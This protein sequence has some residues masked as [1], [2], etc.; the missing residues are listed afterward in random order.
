MI[1]NIPDWVCE[2]PPQFLGAHVKNESNEDSVDSA[3]HTPGSV[4]ATV[5]LII[6]SENAEG[7]FTPAE[8]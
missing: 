5:N 8:V 3:K 6:L 1:I 4:L 7:I 2:R